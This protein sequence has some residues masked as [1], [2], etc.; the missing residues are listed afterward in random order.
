[1]VIK[2][3]IWEEGYIRSLGLTHTHIA[4]VNKNRLYS[5]GDRTQWSVI[6]CTGKDPERG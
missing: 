4:T 2:G 6:S 3:E 5:T 1:M